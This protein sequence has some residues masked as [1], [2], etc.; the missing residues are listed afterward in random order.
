MSLL[1]I[2]TGALRAVADAAERL[3]SGHDHGPWCAD[4]K[5]WAPDNP[6]GRVLPIRISD[7][8]ISQMWGEDGWSFPSK[9]VHLTNVGDGT[10]SF[11]FERAE[12]VD[13]LSNRVVQRMM[14]TALDLS[15]ALDSTNCDL[16]LEAV[17]ALAEFKKAARARLRASS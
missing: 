17:E 1:R 6:G 5:E 12:E 11:V 13:H 14:A 8:V 3:D 4:S 2:A 16:S 15:E 9:A 7:E 10:C